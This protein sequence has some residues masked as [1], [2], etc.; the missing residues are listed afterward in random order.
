MDEDQRSMTVVNDLLHLPNKIATKVASLS[1]LYTPPSHKDVVFISIFLGF[2]SS[3]DQDV[4]RAT[5][6]ANSFNF[7]RLVL[8]LS[9]FRLALLEVG[10]I[11]TNGHL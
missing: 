8:S 9:S 7:P 10:R 3:S 5:V 11:Y 4:H 1:S 6:E 2:E